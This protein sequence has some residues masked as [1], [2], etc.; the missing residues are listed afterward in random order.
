MSAVD[1]CRQCP[2]RSTDTPPDDEPCDCWC[3]FSCTVPE[4]FSFYCL[5]NEHGRCY[6]A[7]DSPTD[8]CMCECHE[9]RK[10]LPA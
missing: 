3:H 4:G 9:K 2:C 6:G 10:E 8:R 1:A 7:L 5:K